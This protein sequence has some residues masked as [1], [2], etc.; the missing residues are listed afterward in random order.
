[1]R[2]KVLDQICNKTLT[3]QVG[4]GDRKGS[5]VLRD[6]NASAAGGENAT[7]EA[8]PPGDPARFPAAGD[9]KGGAKKKEDLIGCLMCGACGSVGHCVLD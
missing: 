8:N 3:A 1:M 2:R 4:D 7:Q 9:G 6:L 5:A